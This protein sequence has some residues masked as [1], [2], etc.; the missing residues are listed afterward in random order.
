MRESEKHQQVL[1]RLDV[2]M[3]KIEQMSMQSSV[4]GVLDSQVEPEVH[5][6]NYLATLPENKV[7][8]ILSVLMPLGD[9]ESSLLFYRSFVKATSSKNCVSP[10]K[11]IAFLLNSLVS[12]Y[13]KVLEFTEQRNRI[14]EFLDSDSDLYNDF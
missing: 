11:K 6:I 2:M 8:D 4:P 5:L 9:E 10:K 7:L 14:E 1:D 12:L 3:Q 13:E